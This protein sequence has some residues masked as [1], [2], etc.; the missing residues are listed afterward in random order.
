[1]QVFIYTLLNFINCSVKQDT[2]YEIAKCLL[3]NV[4]KL[5]KLSL[6]ETAFLCNVSV[7]TL[8][9]FY[10]TVGFENFSTVRKLLKNHDLPFNYESFLDAYGNSKEYVDAMT[11]GLYRIEEI[12]KKVWL[13]IARMMESA[14]HIYLLGYGDFHYQAGYF[15]NIMLYHGKLLEIVNQNERL[16]GTITADNQDLLIVTSLSG[17]Y[18]NNMKDKLEA[19][20]CRKVLITMQD[21]GQYSDFDVVIAIGECNDKN[22]NKYFIMRVFEKI[23][24]S[25]YFYKSGQM[26]TSQN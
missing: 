5:G 14:K 23:I 8:N 24:S 1:M 9:R 17:G 21:D 16:S 13:R 2:D 4:R 6:E 20:K 19:L 7:S 18:V 22:M 10:R 15:Q 25:F 11:Q 12:D 3:E 26:L